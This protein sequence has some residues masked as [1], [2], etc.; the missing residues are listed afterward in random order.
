VKD[1]EVVRMWV[2]YDHPSDYPDHF[3]A[4]LHEADASGSRP[5]GSIVQSDDLAKLRDVLAFEMR[6]VCLTRDPT[7]DAKIMEVWL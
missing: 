2:V 4:R 7:D 1:G 3:V 5:T 6:L